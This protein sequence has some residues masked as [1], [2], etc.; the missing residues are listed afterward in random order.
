MGMALIIVPATELIVL[1]KKYKQ[2]HHNVGIPIGC[3]IVHLTNT[4]VVLLLLL[5]LSS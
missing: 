5:V 2:Q 4:V 3:T 1:D